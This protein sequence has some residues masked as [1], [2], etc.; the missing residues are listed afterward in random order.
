MSTTA[1]VVTAVAAFMAG[2]SGL[3][4]F[5][6]AAYVVGPLAEYGV[7]RAWWNLLGAAKVA[8]AVGLVAGIWV[9]VIGTLAAIGLILYFAGAVITVLRARSYGHVPFPLVYMAPAVAA[10]ALA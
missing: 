9:P 1:I 10:L 2:F 8:G 5:L 7:P 6:K 3:S 4:V